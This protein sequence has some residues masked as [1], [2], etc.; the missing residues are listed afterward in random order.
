MAA[1]FGQF[2]RRVRLYGS[3]LRYAKAH[4]EDFA[5]ENF[6][7]FVRMRQD[8]ATWSS[9]MGDLRVLDLGCGKS[10]WLT[11][12]LHSCGARVTGIDTEIVRRGHSVAKYLNLFKENGF[13]RALRTLAWDVLYAR[14]YYQ[15]LAKLAPFPLNFQGLDVRAVEMSEVDL[16]DDSLDLIVSH[17][18]F[19]H[20]SDVDGV[21]AAMRRLLKPEGI[22]YIYIHNFASLSGG[23]HIAW[24]YPD[25]EPSAVVPPWDHLREN[26]YSDIPSWINRLRE[27]DYRKSIER[28]FEVLSWFP[29]GREGASLLT[30]RIR[31]ELADFTEDELLTKGYTVV[32]RS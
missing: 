7:F 11:L 23:H 19:E 4:N 16:P 20:L 2:G 18:V 10:M 1:A 9:D 31:E 28:H 25:T 26:L 3:M 17:E 6:E 15:A 14:P 30:P 12:L 24:K 13:E 8:L 22:A 21:L 29:S 27:A 32:I 5:R